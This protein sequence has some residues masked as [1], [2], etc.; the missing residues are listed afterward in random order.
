MKFNDEFN[1]IIGQ[2]LHLKI[3]YR[4]EGDDEEIPYYYYGI[5]L[6]DIKKPIGKISI[7]IGHNYHSYYNGNIGY[8][9]DEEY[10]GHHYAYEASKLVIPVAK[11]HKMEYLIIT[12]DESNLASAKTIEKLGAKLIEVV[13]PPKDYLF[14][15]EGIEKHK[16]YRLDI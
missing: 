10:Q 13:D 14:Y 3:L 5:F 7:R 16:I 12:C 15:F 2:N 8:D 11:Y 4:D 6:D 9:I 1:I